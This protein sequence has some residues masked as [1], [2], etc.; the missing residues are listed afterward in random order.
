MHCIAGV[1]VVGSVTV[2]AVVT[3]CIG[4]IQGT[5]HTSVMNKGC[6]FFNNNFEKSKE[7]GKIGI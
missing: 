2:A 5:H 3:E 7:R 1:T 6:F 4:L